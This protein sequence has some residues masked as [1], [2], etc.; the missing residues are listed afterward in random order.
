MRVLAT[1]RLLGVDLR[2]NNRVFEV[3]SWR[4]DSFIFDVNPLLRGLDRVSVLDNG[5]KVPRSV[6]ELD[7]KQMTCFWYGDNI[8]FFRHRSSFVSSSLSVGALPINKKILHF[9]NKLANN[10]W[11]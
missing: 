8:D 5:D 7:G 2:S 4:G 9:F 11:K 1:T 10:V 6:T 3:D